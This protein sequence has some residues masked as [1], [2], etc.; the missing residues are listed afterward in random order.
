[1]KLKYVTFILENCDA[2]TIDGKYIGE[3]LIEDIQTS[4]SRVASNCIMKMDIANTVAIEIHKD[5]NKERYP[6]EQIIEDWKETVFDR[7]DE[8]SDITCV[9][10]ELVNDSKVEHYEYYVDWIGDSDYVNE[11]QSVYI[12][13]CGNLYLVI[14]KDK[15]IKDFFD[16]EM[17]DDDEYMNFKWKMYSLD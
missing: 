12:S 13:D 2:I 7:I 16:Y 17:I 14:N 10:F 4:I 15:K 11:A 9:E 3:F 8:H 1:M 6:F 5:A